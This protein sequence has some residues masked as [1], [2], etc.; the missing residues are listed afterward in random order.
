MDTSPQE[1]RSL[2][3][4]PKASLGE[5]VATLTKKTGSSSVWYALGQA[6]ERYNT[7]IR[8]DLERC[9]DHVKDPEGSPLFIK[10]YMTGR[11]EEEASPT[12]A[13]CCAS[14]E[15][16][17]KAEASVRQSGIL[18]RHPGFLLGLCAFPLEISSASNSA[19][20]VDC[21]NERSHTFAA[22]ENGSKVPKL[23]A[24]EV[25]GPRIGRRFEFIIYS[26]TGSCVRNATGGLILRIGNDLYQTTTFLATEPLGQ[27]ISALEP[28][29]DPEC[30]FDNLSEPKDSSD[31]QDDMRGRSLPPDE[32]SGEDGRPD[33]GDQRLPIPLEPG[34]FKLICSP[35]IRRGA[36]IEHTLIRK[37]QKGAYTTPTLLNPIPASPVAL[38]HYAL[39]KLSEL[40]IGEASN[41]FY[42]HGQEPR[43]IESLEVAEVG[44]RPV[45]V[46]VVTHCGPLPGTVLPGLVSLKLHGSPHFQP[47]HTVTISESFERGDRGSAVVDAATGACYG[48]IIFGVEGHSVAYMVPAPDTLADIVL[49]FG[50][51]PSLQLSQPCETEVSDAIKRWKCVIPRRRPDCRPP[52]PLDKCTS[53]STGKLYSA[54]SR[55][56]AH[57]RRNHCSEESSSHKDSVE[58]EAND[59]S[60]GLPEADW[61]PW[62]SEAT[63]TPLYARVMQADSD[64]ESDYD[65]GSDDTDDEPE[66]GLPSPSTTMDTADRQG[67]T[68][69]ESKE[70]RRHN[71][72]LKDEIGLL[73]GDVDVLMEDREELKQELEHLRRRLWEQEALLTPAG[74]DGFLPKWYEMSKETMISDDSDLSEERHLVY[75]QCA[76]DAPAQAQIV[77]RRAR[78]LSLLRAVVPRGEKKRAGS[79]QE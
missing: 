69:E 3:P 12:I 26:E 17:K 77:R 42:G 64:S 19:F 29:S 1:T 47:V 51:L 43:R 28:F 63:V 22:N 74:P 73:E 32:N 15:T 5:K 71:E 25:S 56:A 27:S 58:Q 4:D 62:I 39:V 70:L 11:K 33:D 60:E 41:I 13:I 79:R 50:K 6:T 78:A 68:M 66:K 55:A 61:K 38:T 44:T 23:D 18:D 20:N 30:Q 48:H 67:T 37:D 10:L 59:R 65:N 21:E 52:D 76:R 40:E 36:I 8:H 2:S 72:R 31:E 9:L 16:R 7:D 54:R 45:S 75:S 24:H 46:F 57:L 14:R 53:C 35:P 34:T 49:N